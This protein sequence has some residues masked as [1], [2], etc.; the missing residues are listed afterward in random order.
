MLR[1]SPSNS[2]MSYH[3]FLRKE[4]LL[5]YRHYERGTIRAPLKQLALA[6]VQLTLKQLHDIFL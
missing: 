5:Y 1:Q 4:Q 2:E 6:K 3:H